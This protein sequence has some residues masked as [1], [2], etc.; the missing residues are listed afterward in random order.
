MQELLKLRAVPEQ[1]VPVRASLSCAKQY[2]CLLQRDQMSL[3]IYF[4]LTFNFI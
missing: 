3:C 2:W 4:K 1:A